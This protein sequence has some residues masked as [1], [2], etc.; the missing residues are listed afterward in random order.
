MAKNKKRKDNW[1]YWFTIGLISCLLIAPNATV[2]RVLVGHIEPLEFTFLRSALIVVVSI[3]I[4]LLSIHK[5]NR[6]NLIYTLG[7]GL[8]MTIA[9][10]CLTYAVKYSDASYAVIMSLLS[11]IL[12]IVL[13]NRMMGDKISFRAAAGVALAAAGALVVVIT[14]LFING[15]TNPHFYPLATTLLLINNLFFTLGIIFSRK[16][17]ESGMPLSANA[18]LMSFVILAIS[19]LAMYTTEGLP[20]NVFHFSLSTW[21]GIFYSGIIVVFLA[22]IMNI[23][24]YEHIG[25]ATISGL[26]YLGTIVGII[27]PVVILSEKPSS[28][29]AIGGVLIFVG[30]FLTEKHRLKHHRYIHPH[31]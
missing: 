22:R 17:N 18:G 25:A 19:F 2:I 9:T 7:A 27:I 11:P 24:S 6:R 28:T 30:L 20:S 4:I 14:P 26:S 15:D 31:V 12:L 3:P 1:W 8:C 29:V 13:S 21:L 10:I 5:F 23:A 16:S